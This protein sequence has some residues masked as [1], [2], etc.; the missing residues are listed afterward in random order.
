MLMQRK[1]GCDFLLNFKWLADS[2][3]FYKPTRFSSM[4]LYYLNSTELM[5]S[6]VKFSSGY[7]EYTLSGITCCKHLSGVCWAISGKL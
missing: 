2:L 1:V 4:F 6:A 3:D 5:L 7:T